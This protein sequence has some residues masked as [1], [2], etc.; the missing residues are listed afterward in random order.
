MSVI[1][2]LVLLYLVTGQLSR[3]KD[4]GRKETER[5][6]AQRG[7]GRGPERAP[8]GAGGERAEGHRPSKRERVQDK[9]RQSWKKRENKTTVGEKTVQKAE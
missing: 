9:Q 6:R 2:S 7:A 1:V 4:T 5:G 8:E 3:Q